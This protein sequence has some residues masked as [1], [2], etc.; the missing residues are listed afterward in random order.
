M[1]LDTAELFARKHKT[2]TMRDWIERL[3]NFLE[4]NAY[5]VL[6][7]YGKVR[8]DDAER[9]AWAEYEIFRVKQDAEFSSDFDKMVDKIKTGKTLPKITD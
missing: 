8:R 6:D 1:Y 9:H 4:F 5:E 2:M 3:D 7:N